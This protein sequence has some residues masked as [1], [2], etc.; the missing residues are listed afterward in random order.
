MRNEKTS[1]QMICPCSLVK[2]SLSL[3]HPGREI[4]GDSSPVCGLSFDPLKSGLFPKGRVCWARMQAKVKQETCMSRYRNHSWSTRSSVGSY[5]FERFV[6]CVADIAEAV[7]LV[8]EESKQRQLQ[9]HTLNRAC[10]NVSVAVRKLM[11]DGN[12]FLFKENVEPLIH[13]LKDPRRRPKK[14]LRPDVL[15][16]TI[17]GMSIHYIVGESEEE[18]TFSAPGYEHR[19]VVNPLH[20]LLRT[21]KEEYRLDDPFDWG[22]QPMKFSR[23]MNTKVLQVDDAVLSAERVLRLLANYEGAHV[24]LNEMTRDNA[25]LPVKA[26]LADDNDELYR[27]GNWVTFG[28]VSYFHVFTLLIGV[29]LVNMTRETLKRLSADPERRPLWQ[30]IL[31]APSRIAS[32]TLLL[33]KNFSIG[34]VFENTREGLE[35]VGNSEKPGTTLIQTPEW[36]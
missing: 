8:D 34:M 22:A 2:S 23:W 24:E 35:V 15:V 27:R 9:T 33:H 29:Y 26:K 30:S 16:E 1:L 6:E 10:R 31:R 17:G 18:R 3:R 4:R 21:G 20:G 5:T 19:T 11:L 32:P 36:R 25:S 14:G 28:G 13:P 12:G 7:K